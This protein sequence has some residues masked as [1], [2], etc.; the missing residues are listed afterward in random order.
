MGCRCIG[1]DGYAR[2]CGV[3]LGP[4]GVRGGGV[5]GLV[6]FF[7]STATFAGRGVI[8]F[9]SFICATYTTCV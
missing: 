8:A 1:S 6:L 9:Y 7:V 4:G 2:E 3:F 5:D